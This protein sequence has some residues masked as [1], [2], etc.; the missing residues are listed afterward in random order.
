M[1]SKV[2]NV[3]D[4]ACYDNL[5]LMI[6]LEKF[7]DSY[8]DLK[9]RADGNFKNFFPRKQT[10]TFAERQ[11]NNDDKWLHDILGQ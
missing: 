7:L 2:Y 4:R 8:S 6:F 3:S 5:Y 10:M 9:N 1:A 11:P